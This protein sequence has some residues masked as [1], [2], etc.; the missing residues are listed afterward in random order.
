MTMAATR[1]P[2]RNVILLGNASMG[3]DSL[4]LFNKTLADQILAMD[5]ANLIRFLEENIST[6]NQKH[7]AFSLVPFEMEQN[8]GSVADA[9]TRLLNEEQ[10]FTVLKADVAQDFAFGDEEILLDYWGS[11][12]EV[13]GNH[14][15][16]SISSLDFL[17]DQEEEIFLLL[18]VEHLD[19]MIS[20]LDEHANELRVMDKEKVDRLKEWRDFCAANPNYLAAYF[21]DF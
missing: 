4:K 18:R 3:T 20:S 7:S 14:P 11:Y 19:Q 10:T 16:G 17:S 5:H 2:K 15:D 21:F 1:P 9:I 12:V 6:L 13:F 8:G